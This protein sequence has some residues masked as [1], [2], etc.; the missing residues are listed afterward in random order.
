MKRPTDSDQVA[1]ST[2]AHLHEKQIV[3]A[4]LYR[5]TSGTVPKRI[6]NTALHSTAVQPGASPEKTTRSRIGSSSEC[7]P[8]ISA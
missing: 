4:L 5:A 3:I 2:S 7:A 1:A 6:R 8:V